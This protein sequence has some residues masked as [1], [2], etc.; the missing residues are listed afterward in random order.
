MKRLCLAILSVAFVSVL[1]S[2]EATNSRRAGGGAFDE[3]ELGRKLD[4]NAHLDD[5]SIPGGR[6]FEQWREE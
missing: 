1:A 6:S 3:S 4:A 2:C 5:P